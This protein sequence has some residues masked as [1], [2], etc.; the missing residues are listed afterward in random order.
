MFGSGNGKSVQDDIISDPSELSLPLVGTTTF[1][2]FSI[3]PNDLLRSNSLGV[4][5]TG[6]TITVEYM[7]GGGLNTNVSVPKQLIN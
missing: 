7:S 4:S 1:K 3:D 5:P 2:K 6:T